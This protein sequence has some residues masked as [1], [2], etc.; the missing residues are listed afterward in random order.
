M[1]AKQGKYTMEE[2]SQYSEVPLRVVYEHRKCGRFDFEDLASVANYV[3][4]QKLAAQAARIM[5]AGH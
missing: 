4:S 1:R 3:V 2:I 5:E